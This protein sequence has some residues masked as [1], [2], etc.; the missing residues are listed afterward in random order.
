M[1]TPDH[2]QTLRRIVEQFSQA[3]RL[4]LMLHYAEQLSIT[5]IALV[6]ELPESRI[7]S[8]LDTI[9]CRTAR[10]LNVGAAR[11]A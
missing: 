2:A 3:E 10:E 9:R 5:E 6:L 4:I 7:E 11:P 1:M 8:T